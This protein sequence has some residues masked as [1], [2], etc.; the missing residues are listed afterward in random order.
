MQGRDDAVLESFEAVFFNNMVLVLDSYFTHRT[1]A[2]EGKDGN[3]M[4]R[5]IGSNPRR[6][7]ATSYCTLT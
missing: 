7:H 5:L 1:R 2:I 4:N 3:P 6:T